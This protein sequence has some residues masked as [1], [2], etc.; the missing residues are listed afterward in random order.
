MSSMRMEEVGTLL[1]ALTGERQEAAAGAVLR[2]AAAA[3]NTGAIEVVLRGFHSNPNTP[4]ARGRTALLLAVRRGQLGALAA[5]LRYGAGAMNGG[6]AGAALREAAWAGRI[7]ALQLL[8]DHAAGRAAINAADFPGQ[9]PVHMAAIR[10]HVG[11][12]QVLVAAGANMLIADSRG[13]TALHWAA[14]KKGTALVA[15]LL[16]RAAAE[17]GIAKKLLGACTHRG[18]TAL[19]LAVACGNDEVAACLRCWMAE[20]E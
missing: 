20:S 19:Q 17:Q 5:L 2:L 13:W 15:E 12:L 14:Y 16:L 8:L 1:A 9:A 11:T 4:D 3:G 10:S 6:T 7:H 18:Q